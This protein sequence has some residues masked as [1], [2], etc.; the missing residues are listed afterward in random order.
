M[1]G[2]LVACL[3]V[4]ASLP[5]FGGIISVTNSTTGNFDSS[6]GTRSLTFTGAEPGFG[7]GIISDA[8]ISINFAKAD[9]EDFDPP[10]PSGTP[11]FNEVVFR[12]TAPNGVTLAAL[13]DA[14]SFNSGSSGTSFD[15]T[16]TFYDAAALIVNNDVNLIQ[17]GAFRPIN[18]LGIFNGL[19]AGGTWTLYIEDTVGSDSLRFRSA[20]LTF[21]TDGTRLSDVPEP[22]TYALVGMGM[23]GVIAV[24][25]RRE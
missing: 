10:F 20:T 16:I 1:K 19:N 18:P 7:G 13:I 17:P 22:S 14:D 4:I 11:F 15:G 6:F 21:G 24:R 5:S 12:L 23:L 3:A 8:S 9:G 25:R 2:F